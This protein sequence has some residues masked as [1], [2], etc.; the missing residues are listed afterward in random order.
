ME[1]LEFLG[2]KGVQF[3]MAV[4]AGFA[5]FQFGLNKKIPLW[6]YGAYA[7][8]G[9]LV[10]LN[11]PPEQQVHKPTS[12]IAILVTGAG[13][14]IG[15]HAA[16]TLIDAGYFVFAGVRKEADAIALQ[17]LVSNKSLLQVITLDITEPS[18]VQQAV[19]TVQQSGLKLVGL[20][21]NAG[22][23]AFG[24]MELSERELV[25]VMNVNF[26]AHVRVTNAMLPLLRAAHGRVLFVS[27]LAGRV[28]GLANGIYCASKFAL[29]AAADAYRHELYSQG[30]AVSVIEPGLIDTNMPRSLQGF[31]PQ[32]QA[33]F[34]D[35]SPDQ[36]ALYDPLMKSYNEQYQVS[37]KSLIGDT[38]LT[39]AAIVHALTAARPQPRYVVGTDALL[40]TTLRWLIPDTI[41]DRIM[42]LAMGL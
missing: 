14:G 16:C 28:A 38:T 10:L 6:V 35:A 1:F 12:G 22:K 27:S 37:A 31:L 40:L 41:F 30:I 23:I 8:C 24:P 13:A 21:N 36:L 4:G 5:G 39:S 2:E 29:E 11:R 32:W 34:P 25:D 17:E 15:K 9:A 42:R 18:Q 7:V 19:Q 26:F 3:L 33:S 20:V